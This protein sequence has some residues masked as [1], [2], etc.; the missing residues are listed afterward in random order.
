MGRISALTEL[1]SLESNDYLIVLDSSANIA[2]K[3]TIA[4]AFGL[5][6]FGFTATGE[7]WTFS[8]WDSTTKIGVIT[9]PTDAT[10]KYSAGMRV[11]FTQTTGGTKFGIIHDVTATTLSVF[12]GTDYTLNNE[13]ITSPLYST[14]YAPKGFPASKEKWLI[15]AIDTTSR[16]SNTP[17]KATW[18][19]PSGATSN[20]TLGKGKYMLGM[21]VSARSHSSASSTWC[22]T[23]V[24]VSTSTSSAT[25][26]EFISSAS[27]DQ[28]SSGLITLTESFKREKIV[29]ITS[30]TTYRI[31]HY[32]DVHGTMGNT[33]GFESNARI[34]AYSA[35]I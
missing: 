30:N 23:Q 31:I 1:T 34:Y 6:S 9:V 4:N 7:S 32:S 24:A 3:I 15:Q 21:E 2:K 17:S 20:I 5:P 25:D 29:T 12:F 13:A 14:E 8:S 10:T 22:Q 18:Y 27:S 35:Y 16:K 28:A 26:S 11:K 19:L 33:N